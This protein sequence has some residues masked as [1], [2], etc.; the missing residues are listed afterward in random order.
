MVSLFGSKGPGHANYSITVLSTRQVFEYSA[1]A[2]EFQP[3]QNL[4]S[5][6]FTADS[7]IHVSSVVI[8][9]NTW[10]DIDYITIRNTTM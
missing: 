2:Q 6:S 8:G 5:E 4:W 10:L 1:L 9:D 7:S 3:M